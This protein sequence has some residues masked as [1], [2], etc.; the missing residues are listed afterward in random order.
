MNHVRSTDRMRQVWPGR[1]IIA[2]AIVGLGFP[3]VSG[4]AEAFEVSLPE[5]CARETTE[6]NRWPLRTQD[7]AGCPERGNGQLVLQ[8]TGFRREA[9]ES[10]LNRWPYTFKAE[11]IESA[12]ALV[13]DGREHPTIS[14][15]TEPDLNMWP[16]WPKS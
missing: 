3:A 16:L 11:Q 8:T 5:N 2:V 14:R 7:L 10:A 1:F 15:R 13:Y 9:E 12:K 6:L 4:T